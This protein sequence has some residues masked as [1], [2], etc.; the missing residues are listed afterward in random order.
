MYFIACWSLCS[1]SQTTPDP[2][3]FSYRAYLW[4][5][6]SF[7]KSFYIGMP[8]ASLGTWNWKDCYLETQNGNEWWLPGNFSQNCLCLNM[9]AMKHPA[10][11]ALEVWSSLTKSGWVFIL[12]SSQSAFLTAMTPTG[13]TPP[14]QLSGLCFLTCYRR[15]SYCRVCLWADCSCFVLLSCSWCWS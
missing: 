3:P 10:S 7:A 5:H 8:W 1:L 14:P 15:S 12:I 9:L 4:G 2:R 6:V 13:N 11:D